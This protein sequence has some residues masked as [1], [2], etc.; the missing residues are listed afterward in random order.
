MCCDAEVYSSEMKY[1]CQ[2][3]SMDRELGLQLATVCGAQYLSE[4]VRRCLASAQT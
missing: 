4:V 3:K 2:L 1:D